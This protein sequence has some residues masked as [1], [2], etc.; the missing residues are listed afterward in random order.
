M[1]KIPRP[2]HPRPQ[3][4]RE[5]WINLNGEWQ[6]EIDHGKSGRDRGLYKNT[7]LNSSIIVPFCPESELS[8]INNKDFMECV[9]YKRKVDIKNDWLK[10]GRRTIL[11][12]DA[13]DYHTE[14]WINGDSVGTHI[15]GYSS[16]SFDITEKLIKGDNTVTVCATDLLRTGEQPGGKQCREF[17]SRGCSYTRTTGIWQ[18]VWLENVA[19]SSI[20]SFKCTPDIYSSS[21]Y[22]DVL[23]RNANGKKV[24]ATAYF[25]GKEVGSCEAQIEGKHARFNMEL[26]ELHLW[27]C[28]TPN[29]YDLVLE[30]DNDKMSGYFGMRST[31]YHGNKFYL[32][33]QVVFQRLILDQGFYPDGI[34]T[35]PTDQELINDIKRSMDMG[36]NG[37]RL[38]QKVFEPRFLYHCDVLG[39]LVWEEH[40]NW[41][42]NISKDKAW[43]RFVPEWLEIMERDYNHPSIIGWCAFNETQKDQ[44]VNLVK[45]VADMTRAFDSTRPVI[46]TSGWVHIDGASDLRDKHDYDQNPVT[47]KERYDQIGQQKKNYDGYVDDFCAPVFISE[48]GG[49]WWSETDTSG[50]GYGQRPN[51]LDEVIE[52]YRGLTE[53]LL[54]NPNIGA[55][56]YTQLTDV[57]QEQNGLYTYDRKPKMD[58][59]IIKEINKQK[60]AV[61][62]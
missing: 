36:F 29:L 32:N 14:V 46:D 42:L 61:E 21:I 8:G 5:S 26:K 39:Y 37:A 18:T 51:S 1:T 15:G 22:F 10:D 20:K 2:E 12:I 17:F 7:E 4:Y 44:N 19:S 11:H 28:E 33:N 49:I 56:C 45:Y 59:A 60:A 38:H 53:V 48:Y 54:N 34:Y 57:E 3:M 6:F 31:H 50:W 30:L 9:W 62:K 55:F 23:C 35:A 27:S 58:P 41:E 13:C 47:F 52:R 25:A 43:E 40:A 16:F 24:K